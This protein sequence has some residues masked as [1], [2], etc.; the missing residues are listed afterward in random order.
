MVIQFNIWWDLVQWSNDD[1]DWVWSR[2]NETPR[3]KWAHAYAR[4]NAP[5]KCSL[6]KFIELSVVR[7]VCVYSPRYKHALRY[8]S[9]LS[10]AIVIKINRSLSHYLFFFLRMNVAERRC[11]E[12]QHCYSAYNAWILLQDGFYFFLRLVRCK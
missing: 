12:Q 1:D 11:Q 10:K 8:A 5:T 6:M 4:Y 7:G 3:H 2:K 9:R